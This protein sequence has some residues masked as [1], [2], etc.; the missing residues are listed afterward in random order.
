M[1]R[2]VLYTGIH[3]QELISFAQKA[4]GIIKDSNVKPAYKKN[5]S[6]LICTWEND[7]TTDFISLVMSML[8][9][10]AIK[11]NPVYRHSPKLHEMA[12]NL[13]STAVYE[14]EVR[15]L[16]SYIRT[17]RTLNIEGYITFRMG[18]YINKLDIMAYTMIKKLKLAERKSSKSYAE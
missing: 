6:R 12:L 2:L 11:N 17:S 1:K 18:E 16:K 10:I 3:N 9:E 4:N 7:A 5:F 14:N 15:R 13:R 8:E